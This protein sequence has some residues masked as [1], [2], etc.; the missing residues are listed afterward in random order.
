MNQIWVTFRRAGV[1]KYPAAGVDPQLADSS[2]LQFEHRHLFY[3]K[4]NLEVFQDD[5]CVEYHMLLRW[6]ES[7]YDG[8]MLNFDNQ[9]CE[10]IARA[11]GEKVRAEYPGR[12]CAVEVSEDGECGSIIEF[13]VD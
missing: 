9:S 5:R 12:W 6:A 7:L 11:L 8:G 2:Y 4:I 13:P 3:V 10:M 1:H